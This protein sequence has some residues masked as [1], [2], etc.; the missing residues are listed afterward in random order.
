[1]IED[2]V[3]NWDRDLFSERRKNPHGDGDV[4]LISSEEYINTLSGVSAT[5]EHENKKGAVEKL[6]NETLEDPNFKGQTTFKVDNLIV[7]SFHTTDE[8]KKNIE[9]YINFLN[10]K[11]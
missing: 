11:V 10:N 7:V 6:F 3:Y 1:M 5:D 9:E 8:G 4:L 2:I